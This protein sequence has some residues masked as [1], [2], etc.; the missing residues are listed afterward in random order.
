MGAAAARMLIA[1]IRG[2]TP[3]PAS[4]DLGFELVVRGST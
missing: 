1:L 4:I 2:E 3:T